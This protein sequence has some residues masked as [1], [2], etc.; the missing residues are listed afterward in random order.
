MAK[1]GRVMVSLSDEALEYVEEK[2]KRMGVSKSVVCAMG[3]EKLRESDYV[4]SFLNKIP[5]GEMQ[6]LISDE[7]AKAGK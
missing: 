5:D 6:K 7:I 4:L 2:A 3:I 1:T